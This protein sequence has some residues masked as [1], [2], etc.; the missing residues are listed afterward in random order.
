MNIKYAH[1]LADQTLDLVDQIIGQIFFSTQIFQCL[2][3]VQVYRDT[4]PKGCDEKQIYCFH[5]FFKSCT[6]CNY[7]E[8]FQN[9]LFKQIKGTIKKK[10]NHCPLSMQK[11]V[12]FFL[13]IT[14]QRNFL[15]YS[16]FSLVFNLNLENVYTPAS[17]YL[18][19]QGRVPITK[20]HFLSVFF[21]VIQYKAL[22][23]TMFISDFDY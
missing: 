4:L 6:F 9:F 8:I 5:F 19:G 13:S 16:S 1:H 15:C 2:I 12:E 17:N 10:K 18:H 22:S 7:Q 3:F 21:L 14:A 11:E 20:V 23:V